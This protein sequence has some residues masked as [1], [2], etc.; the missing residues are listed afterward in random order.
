MTLR[1]NPIMQTNLQQATVRNLSHSK[2]LS[3][4]PADLTLNRHQPNNIKYSK[5]TVT[6]VLMLHGAVLAGTLALTNKPEVLPPPKADVPMMVSLLNEIPVAP[7]ID[8]VEPEP[9]PPKPVVNPKPMVKKVNPKP[10]AEVPIPRPVVSEEPVAN[11]VPEPIAEESTPEPET[12][13]VLAKAP[14]VAEKPAP[15]RE[16]TE[17][18][19]FGVAY[20]NNPKPQYPPMSRRIGEEGR[21]LFKVLVNANGDPETVEIAS[22][23][24]S[25]RLDNAAL[26]AVKQW[27]FVPAKRNNVAISAYVTVPISF[28]LDT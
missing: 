20:L 8:K 3:Y 28:A 21:V 24:G 16:I 14:A 1:L 9:V 27:R 25:E 15:K 6:V 22:S 12:E 11:S 7:V 4:I 23:S 18:P 19:K 5:L 2:I 10:V 17:S 13:T 26:T